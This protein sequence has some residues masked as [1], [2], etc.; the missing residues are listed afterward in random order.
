MADDGITYEREAIEA[1]LQKHDTSPFTGAK[2]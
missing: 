2:L 1:W